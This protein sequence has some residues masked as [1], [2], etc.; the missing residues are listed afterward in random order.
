MQSMIACTILASLKF[1]RISTS[2]LGVVF[3]ANKFFIDNLWEKL[4]SCHYH[5]YHIIGVSV[6]RLLESHD[7]FITTDD[8]AGNSELL[9]Q[10]TAIWILS[11]EQEQEKAAIQ[12]KTRGLFQGPCP[13][14][15]DLKVSSRHSIYGQG[16]IDCTP[17]GLKSPNKILPRVQL[18]RSFLKWLCHTFVFRLGK[19]IAF[20]SRKIW[21]SW[22]WGFPQHVDFWIPLDPRLTVR[23]KPDCHLL[24]HRRGGLACSA[25]RYNKGA[26]DY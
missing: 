2:F 8:I 18:T 26:V 10:V 5:K 6:V 19:C 24:T 9:E 4:I 21:K 20:R 7:H 16:G 14:R 13:C 17:Q 1:N 12:V 23:A 25:V 3:L 11:Y 15:A 22:W